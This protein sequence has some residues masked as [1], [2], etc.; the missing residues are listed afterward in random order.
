MRSV[1]RVHG[2]VLDLESEF[3]RLKI[4][5][6]AGDV[7]GENFFAFWVPA[8]HEFWATAEGR[9]FS[10]QEKRVAREKK[11]CARVRDPPGRRELVN[12]GSW[13]IG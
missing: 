2:G 11:E 13:P 6:M 10:C 3:W 8:C 12:T 5:A 7:G 9:N 4:Q 1:W